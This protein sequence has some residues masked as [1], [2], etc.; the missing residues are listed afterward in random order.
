MNLL[1]TNINSSGE[2]MLLGDFNIAVNKAFDAK[3]AT[4]LDILDSFNLV[5]KVDKP[6]HRLSNTLN[7][8]IHDADSNIIPRIKVDRLFSDH[9]IVLFDISTPCTITN[10]KV[11]VYRKFKDINPYAFMKDVQEFCL[12]KPPGPCLDDKTNHYYT[13]LQTPLDHHAP[14]KSHKCSN[15][16]RFPGS[17]KICHGHQTLKAP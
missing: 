3:P 14:I 16:P 6:T 15:P 2:L 12:N 5:N 10:S 8:I 17:T 11:Q 4:F 1:K 13:M 9:N 7:L